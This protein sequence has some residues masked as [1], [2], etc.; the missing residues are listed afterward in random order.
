MGAGNIFTLPIVQD[1]NTFSMTSKTVNDIRIK[2]AFL[3]ISLFVVVVF[4]TSSCVV[5][6]KEL[7]LALDGLIIGILYGR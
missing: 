5:A 6:L 3:W 1:R 4:I 2:P 7:L